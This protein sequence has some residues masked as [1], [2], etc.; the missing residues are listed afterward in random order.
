MSEQIQVPRIN[1]ELNPLEQVWMYRVSLKIFKY[2]LFYKPLVQMSYSSIPYSLIL[3]LNV[4]SGLILGA[5][6]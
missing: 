6:F 4:F 3:I 1:E 5:N 2:G